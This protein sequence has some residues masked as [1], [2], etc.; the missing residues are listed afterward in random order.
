MVL[1]FQ[2]FTT[3]RFNGYKAEAQKFILNSY[4]AT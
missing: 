4:S 2:F 1:Q 3:Y